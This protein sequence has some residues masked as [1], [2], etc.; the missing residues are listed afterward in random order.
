MAARD[1]E[2]GFA[3]AVAAR[4]L[5]RATGLLAVLPLA[6]RTGALASR[7]GFL[8]GAAARLAGL[9]AVREDAAVRA[10]FDAGFAAG[11]E[12]S[13]AAGFAAFAELEA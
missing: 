12:A 8:A 10:S 3:A 9:A 2:A 7:V 6:F 11:L 13:L 1:L 5:P 4:E